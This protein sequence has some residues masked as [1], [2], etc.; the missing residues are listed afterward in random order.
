VVEEAPSPFP[1]AFDSFDRES[2]PLTELE[3]LARES[4]R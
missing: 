2:P 3:E 1:D 4:F